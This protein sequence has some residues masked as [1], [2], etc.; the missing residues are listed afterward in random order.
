MLFSL[1][2]GVRHIV[3]AHSRR[4]DRRQK[5]ARL[6]R[7]RPVATRYLCL[8]V[9]YVCA[10]LPGMSD[11]KKSMTVERSSDGLEVVAVRYINQPTEVDEIDHVIVHLAGPPIIIHDTSGPRIPKVEIPMR[12][13]PCDANWSRA[14][15]I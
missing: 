13:P 7:R 6:W 10:V 2:V 9:D 15:N 14:M 4:L 5:V 11:N 1:P 3:Y 12:F 8:N